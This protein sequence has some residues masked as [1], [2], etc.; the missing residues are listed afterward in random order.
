VGEDV[1]DVR[2]QAGARI[3]LREVAVLLIVDVAHPGELG[4][5]SEVPREVLAPLAETDLSQT[6]GSAGGA[7]GS[8]GRH[9]QAMEGRREAM[10]RSHMAGGGRPTAPPRRGESPRSAVGRAT[11]NFHTFPLP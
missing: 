5:R 9:E 4:E 2:R 6:S 7:R 10:C 8:L 1:G 3:A 11:Y